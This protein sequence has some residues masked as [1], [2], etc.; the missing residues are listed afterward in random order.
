[1][2]PNQFNLR[3]LFVWVAVCGIVL[4]FAIPIGSYLLRM[5]NIHIEENLPK[6]REAEDELA[7]FKAQHPG[8]T[9]QRLERHLEDLKNGVAQ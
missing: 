3:S 5:K 4:A 8:E 2:G 7:R 6:I 1:M 9:D